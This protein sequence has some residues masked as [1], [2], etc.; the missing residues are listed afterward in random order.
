M[1]T[2]FEQFSQWGQVTEHLEL[3]TVS[4]Y[5][6]GGL[7]DYFIEPYSDDSL[8]HLIDYC[9]HHAIPTKVIGNASNMLIGD[10]VFHG[11]VIRLRKGFDELVFETNRVTVGAG[12]GLIALA[13]KAAQHNLTGLEFV[14]GIPGTVGGALYMNAGAYQKSIYDL[15]NRVY[16]YKKD[17]FVWMDRSDIESSYRMSSFMMH[18]D[19]II[20]KVELQLEAGSQSES[21]IMMKDRLQ[22]RLQS[23]PLDKPSCGSVFRNP[24]GHYAWEYIEGAHLRGT[25]IGDAQISDKHANFIVNNG[26]AKAQDV[27]ALIQLIQSQVFERYHVHL[28]PEVEFFNFHD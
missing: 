27:L 9:K 8:H 4:T 7:C 23:Q 13:Y 25:Q 2:H 11:L 24:E 22:R 17:A 16:V 3:K 5:R 21:E 12:Y 26:N 1:K 15:V 19:W 28:H 6:I 18:P 10:D 20:L 14:S